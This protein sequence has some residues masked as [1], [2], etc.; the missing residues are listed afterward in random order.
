MGAKKS[1]FESIDLGFYKIKELIQLTA[2][3]G[4]RQFF[5]LALAT[6]YR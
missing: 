3:L 4:D 2:D 6:L 1:I 5:L